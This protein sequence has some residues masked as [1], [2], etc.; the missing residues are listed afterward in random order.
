M[1]LQWHRDL[2]RIGKFLRWYAIE[3]HAGVKFRHVHGAG[4]CERTAH[5]EAHHRDLSATV[6]QV[7]G[8]T[9]NILVG[10]TC[11]IEA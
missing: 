8:S 7:P 9:A 2:R 6:F 5:A 3:T 1:G 4:D 10:R 11:E